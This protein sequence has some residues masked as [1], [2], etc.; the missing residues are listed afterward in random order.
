MP[1]TAASWP[2]LCFPVL[3]SSPSLSDDNVRQHSAGGGHIAGGRREPR[4]LSS[5]RRPPL[6][7]ADLATRGHAHT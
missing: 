1:V 2:L 4:R 5:G 7:T 3:V 6:A